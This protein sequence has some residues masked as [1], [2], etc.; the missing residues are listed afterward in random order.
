MSR[1]HLDIPSCSICGAPPP[2]R[3]PKGGAQVPMCQSCA[4]ES[5]I[6][7]GVVKPPER[8]SPFPASFEPAEV[9]NG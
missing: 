9:D 6:V 7:T 5:E 1:E 3:L 8:P 4:L 2:L